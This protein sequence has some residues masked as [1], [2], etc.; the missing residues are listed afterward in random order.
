MAFALVLTA[1]LLFGSQV[2]GQL[3][4]AGLEVTLVSDGARARALLGEHPEALLIADL[5]DPSLEA[6]ELVEEL[7]DARPP[8]LGYY[9][10]VQAEVRERAERVGLDRVVPRS[11][12]AREGAGLVERLAESSSR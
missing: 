2:Q 7:G 10:H 4:A 8:T 11:R 6:L 5:T 12:F 3:R 9:S 1:D